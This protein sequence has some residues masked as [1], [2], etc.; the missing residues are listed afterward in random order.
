MKKLQL[1]ELGV[2]SVGLVI[3]YEMITTLFSIITTLLFSFGIHAGENILFIILPSIL[4]FAFYTIAFF[5]IGKNITPIA[6]F[7][8]RNSDDL[9][10]FNLNKAAVI[11]VVIIA[12][13]LSSF[14]RTIPGILE[15]FTNNFFVYKD[16][17]Y[18]DIELSRW[19]RNQTTFLN[20]LIGFIT[21]IILLLISKRIAAFLGKE[22]QAF[23]L[24]NE[25]I[26]S[27]I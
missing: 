18:D 11:H 5:I 16:E 15:Y 7:F 22:K 23:E 25:K 6:R 19:N 10:E 17:N 1:V 14:L 26:E 12:I 20:S 3:G 4:F 8:C 27:N 9:P 2:I 13:C 24:N 21:G